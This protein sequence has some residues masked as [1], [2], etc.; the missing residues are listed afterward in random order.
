MYK[1]TDTIGEQALKLDLTCIMRIDTVPDRALR[2]DQR[3]E[4]TQL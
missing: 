3:N 4:P 1:N 2:K